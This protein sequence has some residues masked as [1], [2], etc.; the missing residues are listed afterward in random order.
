[1]GII[2]DYG[3]VWLSHEAGDTGEGKTFSVQ[4]KM[5]ITAFSPEQVA[6]ESREASVPLIQTGGF[7]HQQ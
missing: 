6:S 7:F 5:E 1:M 3:S 4:V 2:I